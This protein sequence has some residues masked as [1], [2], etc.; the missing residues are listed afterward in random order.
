M[1]GILTG[2]IV[3]V[4]AGASL[5]SGAGIFTAKNAGT[6][7]RMSSFQRKVETGKIQ[8]DSKKA[9]K[10]FQKCILK[11]FH[12]I[13]FG[14][15]D[16]QTQVNSFRMKR[17][18]NNDDFADLWKIDNLKERNL[19]LLYKYKTK[20]VY[21]NFKGK[22]LSL[23]GR[24]AQS[25]RKRAISSRQIV[26]VMKEKGFMKAA[27]AQ[28]GIEG[29]YLLPLAKTDS[30]KVYHSCRY[31]MAADVRRYDEN[32]EEKQFNP[33]KLFG[34]IVKRNIESFGVTRSKFVRFNIDYPITKSEKTE[35]PDRF[36]LGCANIDENNLMY[37]SSKL[38]V[39]ANACSKLKNSEIDKVR[40]I[41][42]VKGKEKC[43][44]M[45]R[46]E[47]KDH[48]ANYFRS[49]AFL[50]ASEELKAIDEQALKFIEDQIK[51]FIGIER[52][53]VAHVE[54][55]TGNKRRVYCETE[56]VDD[57]TTTASEAFLLGAVVDNASSSVLNVSSSDK[58][59]TIANTIQNLMNNGMSVEDIKS[60]FTGKDNKEK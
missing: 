31:Q 59:F 49:G 27:I 48:V 42:G 3:G 1:V 44:I 40:M 55:S 12:N 15:A 38:L 39:I 5:V 24:L 8:S 18:V 51:G 58:A 33:N 32:G 30:G 57:K 35:R 43:Q 34:R 23:I 50:N 37:Q 36:V 54:K 4:I 25:G 20:E 16:L 11:Q 45:T 29:S 56:V 9:K 13:T 22:K 28:S 41:E 60:V 19:K 7:T 53:E 17:A 52:S 26:D 6:R 46:E 14:F 2:I 21:K 10:K 47:F